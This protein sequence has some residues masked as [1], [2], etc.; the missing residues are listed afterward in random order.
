MVSLALEVAGVD[1]A[2]PVVTVDAKADSGGSLPAVLSRLQPV[3][4]LLKESDRVL[5][6]AW[7]G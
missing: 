6:R 3:G 2:L 7:R 4:H 5:Q 1:R